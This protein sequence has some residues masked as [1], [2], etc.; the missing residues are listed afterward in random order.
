MKYI[1]LVVESGVPAVYGVWTLE[2]EVPIVESRAPLWH[3]GFLL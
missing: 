1:T 2:F 3:L